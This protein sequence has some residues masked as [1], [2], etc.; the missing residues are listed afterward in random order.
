MI[1][2][3][4]RSTVD[5]SKNNRRE[6]HVEHGAWELQDEDGMLS[7]VQMVLVI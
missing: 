7:Q 3:N 2:C 1:G 4:R 6:R 5:S